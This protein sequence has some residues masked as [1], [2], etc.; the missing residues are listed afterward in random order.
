MKLSCAV[1]SYCYGRANDSFPWIVYWLV[2]LV[3][4]LSSS[5]YKSM[6]FS[7]LIT[8]FLVISVNNNPYVPNTVIASSLYDSAGVVFLPLL[9]CGNGSSWYGLSRL[10][11]ICLGINMNMK[12]SSTI[13]S[14]EVFPLRIHRIN[15]YLSMFTELPGCY[16]DNDIDFL[17]IFL[18]YIFCIV[19]KF[20]SLSRTHCMLQVRPLIEIFRS[21]IKASQALS[22]NKSVM[23]TFL[24]F[25]NG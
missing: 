18:F 4:S 16:R 12:L 11:M 24:R 7:A 22:N 2:L 8:S 17:L 5:T 15:L 14:S 1:H 21:P 13:S 9:S 20:R 25:F 3:N 10:I 23:W 6:R 19:A